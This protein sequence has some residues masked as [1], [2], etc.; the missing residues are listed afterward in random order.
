MFKMWSLVDLKRIIFWLILVLCSIRDLKKRQICFLPVIIGI[1][2]GMLCELWLQNTDVY[3]VFL[4]CIPGICLAALAILSEGKIGFG[5]GLIVFMA[6]LYLPLF[7]LLECIFFA[8]LLCTLFGG[9]LILMGKGDRK[10]ELPFV[11]FLLVVAI[12]Q[13]MEAFFQ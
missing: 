13:N 5:D 10:T 9:I 7:E 12:L 6:G 2:Y 1:V 4:R 8:F 11:P 3:A